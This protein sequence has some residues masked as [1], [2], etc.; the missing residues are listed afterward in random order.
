MAN[1]LN[2][3]RSSSALNRLPQLR[4]GL[5]G[6]GTVGEGTYRMLE[7]NLASIRRKTGADLSVV[8]IGIR[9]EKKSRR[10]PR[11]LFTADNMGIVT[12]PSIDLV[13][14]AIGG[15]DPALS[16]VEAALDHGKSVVTANKEMMAKHGARLLEK[17]RAKQIDLHFEAAVGGGIPI[18][19]VLKHQL[20]G[21]DVPMMMGILNGT[22]NYILTAM[23]Q[24]GRPFDEVLAEAQLKGYAEADPTND[25]E[26][27]DTMYKIGI[28]ASIVYGGPV[29]L[30]SVH[31]EGITGVDAIDFEY[32]DVLGYTIKLLG[33]AEE[34]V[35]G[36][37]R[38]RVHPAFVPKA[39]S[40]ASVNDVFNAVWF[41][42]DFVGDLM[43]SG[44]GAGGDP[45]A[46][47]V[48]GDVIDVARNFAAKGTGSALPFDPPRAAAG[49][50]DLVS[51]IYVRLDVLDKPNTLGRISTAFGDHNVG[52]A[53][54]E[55]RTTDA[56]HGEIAF[57]TH[58]VREAQFVAALEAVEQLD[59]VYGV[60]NWIRAVE[61]TK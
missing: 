1:L 32:A 48:V 13:V 50:D 28:L 44:R 60:G 9:D 8:R 59:V 18:V 46:S 40:L 37:V 4:I 45:T 31:R 16:L 33:V 2:P 53:A 27:F 61:V 17:A 11:E 25:V 49:M 21:N 56:N 20:A 23:S 10:A 6:F 22:S 54:M 35:D 47:A 15:I 14:E 5:L 41:H 19:Q 39:H 51:R 3:E 26:G 24:E 52:L 43:F 36:S 55:M 7:D 30:E 58:P 42:G 38:V 12:D 29:P 34:L 57:L